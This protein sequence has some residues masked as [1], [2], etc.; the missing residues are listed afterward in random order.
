MCFYNIDFVGI[1]DARVI[2]L[3]L[4]NLSAKGNFDMEFPNGFFVRKL[5]SYASSVLFA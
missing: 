2:I 1:K 5:P 3:V 4:P